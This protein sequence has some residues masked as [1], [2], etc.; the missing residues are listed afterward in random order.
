MVYIVWSILCTVWQCT[1]GQ[2]EGPHTLGPSLEPSY[3][4]FEPHIGITL[5][6]WPFT[7]LYLCCWTLGPLD[8]TAVGSTSKLRKSGGSGDESFIQAG[9]MYL[10]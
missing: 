3:C 9:D 4:S 6:R 5:E 1:F 8:A 2:Y 7:M 10:V